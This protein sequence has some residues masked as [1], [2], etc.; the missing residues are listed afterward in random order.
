VSRIAITRAQRQAIYPELVLDLTAVGDIYVELNNGDF[1]TAQRFRRQFED[2]MRLLDDIGWE[3]D[4]SGERF[5]ITMA[6]EQ[7]ARAMGRLYELASGALAGDVA[8]PADE[9]RVAERE[10]VACG[11]YASVLGQLADGSATS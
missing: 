5:E 3:P 7:L 10:V 8:R 2:T 4:P 11:A 1:A 9:D 6:P